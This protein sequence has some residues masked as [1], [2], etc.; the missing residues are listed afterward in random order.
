MIVLAYIFSDALGL[1]NGT[2]KPVYRPDAP[3]SSPY[4]GLIF[5]ISI[6][7]LLIPFIEEVIFR[8]VLFKA[9]RKNLKFWLAF[10]LSGVLFTLLHYNNDLNA[11]TNLYV[12]YADS[13]FDLFYNPGLR[14]T[15]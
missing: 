15:A 11:A 2:E 6:I 10:L 13:S 9:L 1:E 8:G 3:E 7:G 5:G 14:E 4:I 12:F